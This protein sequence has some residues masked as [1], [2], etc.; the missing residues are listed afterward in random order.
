[1]ADQNLTNTSNQFTKLSQPLL[2]K[3]RYNPMRDKGYNNSIYLVSNLTDTQT[4]WE[5]PGDIN[6]ITEG[7]PLWLLPWGWLD[8]QKNLAGYNK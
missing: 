8:W 4:G 6:L 1:M 3:C 7:Y 5:K 2:I